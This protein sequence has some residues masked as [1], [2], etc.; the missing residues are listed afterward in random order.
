MMRYYRSSSLHPLV[1]IFT[2]PN[3][4]VTIL[5]P[6][7]YYIIKCNSEHTLR[8]LWAHSGHTQRSLGDHPEIPQ[9]SLRNHSENTQRT[10]REHSENRTEQI[11]KQMQQL[12]NHMSERTH[13]PSK[14]YFCTFPAGARRGGQRESSHFCRDSK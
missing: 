3:T 8:T 9:Q 12:N 10:P 13:V 7:H 14:C 1:E 11:N 5:A 2:R 6:N 4:S